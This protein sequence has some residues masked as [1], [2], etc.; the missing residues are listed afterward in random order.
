MGA[1]EDEFDDSV[2]GLEWN[3]RRTHDA[4][5]HTLEGGVLRLA[6]EPGHLD[7]HGRYSFLGVRQRNFEYEVRTKMRFEPRADNEEAGIVIMQNDRSAIVFTLSRDAGENR[8]RVYRSF[9][10][11]IEEIAETYYDH[12]SVDLKVRGDYL[13]LSFGYSLDGAPG[14]WNTLAEDVDG[15]TLSPAVIHGFNYTGLY[16]G[17]FASSGG[18]ESDN[19]ADYE[20]FRYVPRCGEDRDGWYH[21][22]TRRAE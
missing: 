6:L 3:M 19:S 5:F 7:D 11:E 12:S 9:H 20:F 22:Q 4:P 8:L 18:V 1:F 10:G 2:L 21:R 17:L 16:L 13:N 15:T 14:S